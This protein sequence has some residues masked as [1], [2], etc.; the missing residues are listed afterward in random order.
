VF[1]GPYVA[2]LGSFADRGP[3]HLAR[4]RGWRL[5]RGPCELQELLVDGVREDDL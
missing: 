5:T 4:E 2:G 1:D 3:D